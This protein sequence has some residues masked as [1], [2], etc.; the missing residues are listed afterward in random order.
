MKTNTKA[1]DQ[2]ELDLNS[3]VV[4]QLQKDLD[5]DA[6]IRRLLDKEQELKQGNESLRSQMGDLRELMKMV[7]SKYESDVQQ[8]MEQKKE[9]EG[10]VESLE[11]AIKVSENQG[12][13]MDQMA[14]FFAK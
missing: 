1:S 8:L 14:K 11:C 7:D 3:A 12:S 9:L 10:E 4:D 13:H 5:I 2:D 6:E